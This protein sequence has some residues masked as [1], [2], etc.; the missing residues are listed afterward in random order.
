VPGTPER[1]AEGFGCEDP[2]AAWL[3]SVSSMFGV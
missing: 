3:K 2:V 1:F